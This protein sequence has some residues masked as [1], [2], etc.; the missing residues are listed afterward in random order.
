MSKRARLAMSLAGPAGMVLLLASLAPA[1]A[2]DAA[3]TRLA[4]GVVRPI[5]AGE[6]EQRFT[7]DLQAGR[8]VVIDLARPA[9]HAASGGDDSSEAPMTLRLLDAAGKCVQSA[10]Q[11]NDCSTPRGAA[12]RLRDKA[13]DGAIRLAYRPEQAGSYTLAVH[14]AP[15]SA[16]GAERAELVVRER[17]IPPPPVPQAITLCQDALS[18]AG[19]PPAPRSEDHDQPPPS[20]PCDKP[21]AM[22]AN[23][24][25][26]FTFTAPNREQWVRIEMRSKDI[27][28]KI[29]LLGPIGGGRTFDDAAVIA[30]DDDGAGDLNARLVQRLPGGGTY[31]IRASDVRNGSGGFTLAL[32]SIPTPPPPQ[33]RPLAIGETAGAFD[34]TEPSVGG[35]NPFQLYKLA[36]RAGE[37]LTIDMISDSLDSVLEAVTPFS[38]VTD[39][40]AAD[41]G[42]AVIAKDDDG[43]DGTNARITLRFNQDAAVTIRASILASSGTTGNYT[44]KVTR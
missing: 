12:A 19:T 40:S 10:P 28:S 32:R 39:A 18:R 30:E 7:L 13:E 26:Y 16:A 42:F 11:Q 37:N 31:G 9:A 24:E 4:M 38:A 33:V 20:G 22:D 6:G 34:G 35:H 21:Y 14:V 43:G 25:S 8:G 29:E 17:L 5:E 27:D 41:T 3:N 1:H 23:G 36:G 15:A 2:A 44:L